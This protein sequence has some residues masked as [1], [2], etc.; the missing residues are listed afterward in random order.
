MNIVW[1]SNSAF[2]PNNIPPSC[3]LQ[4]FSTSEQIQLL[5]PTLPVDMVNIIHS[6]LDIPYYIHAFIC[7][8]NIYKTYQQ[9]APF[10]IFCFRHICPTVQSIDDLVRTT[11]LP[12][13][14]S[15]AQKVQQA[16]SYEDASIQ[17]GHD[18]TV[19]RNGH[20]QF[21]PINPLP[22]YRWIGTIIRYTDHRTLRKVTHP[23]L[24]IT[25]Q[26]DKWHQWLQNSIII[27]NDFM[28]TYNS[29]KSYYIVAPAYIQHIMPHRVKWGQI[30]VDFPL[31]MSIL[32]NIHR[33]FTRTSYD[34]YSILIASSCQMNA[35]QWAQVAHLVRLQY[36]YE[37]VVRWSQ[38]QMIFDPSRLVYGIETM[39]LHNA[40]CI[41]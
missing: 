29:H 3:K 20:L 6:F 34:R 5:F 18:V 17:L 32:R 23:C 15:T 30:L 24:L 38:S 21:I 16:P 9:F 26:V 25:S 2:I 40:I 31:E 19:A 27:N 14:R 7:T 37:K 13:S 22:F 1:G 10:Y 8:K 11:I 35:H 33:Y 36:Q 39:I 41:C 28:L 12:P 4:V